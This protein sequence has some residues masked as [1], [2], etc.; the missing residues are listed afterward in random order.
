[1]LGQILALSLP[2]PAALVVLDAVELAA[3]GGVPSGPTS[4]QRMMAA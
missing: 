1:M 4:S 2:L 3:A